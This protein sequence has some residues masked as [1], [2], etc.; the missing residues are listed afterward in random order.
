[1]DQVS[2]FSRRKRRG[3]HYGTGE[4]ICIYATYGH[5]S[6]KWFFLFDRESNYKLKMSWVLPNNFGCSSE[7]LVKESDRIQVERAVNPYFSMTKA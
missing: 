1:M 5:R 4:Y 6:K 2:E 7:C 3:E